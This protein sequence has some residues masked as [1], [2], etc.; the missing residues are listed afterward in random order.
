MPVTTTDC[1]ASAPGGSKLLG[2]ELVRFACAMAVL[3]W[4]FHHFAMVGDGS[5]M[6]G[7]HMPLGTLLYPF[8]HFGLFGVQIFWCISGFIFYWKY[9]GAIANRQVEPKRFSGSGSRGFTRSIW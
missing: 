3:V 7:P 1:G 5:A 9:A 2:L 8:Y 6:Y 4:H